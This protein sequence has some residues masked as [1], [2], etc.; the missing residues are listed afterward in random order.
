MYLYFTVTDTGRVIVTVI[1]SLGQITLRVILSGLLFPA[2]SLNAVTAATG[3]G[4]ICANLF[5]LA[6][7]YL[8]LAKSRRIRYS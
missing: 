2:L 8:W 5:W 6:I 7:R 3:I 1:G 4:W